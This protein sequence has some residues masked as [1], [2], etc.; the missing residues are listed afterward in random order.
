[1]SR[2][3]LV[4]SSMPIAAAQPPGTGGTPNAVSL[5]QDP[6]GLEDRKKTTAEALNAAEI[7]AWFRKI[8]DIS[9]SQRN[10]R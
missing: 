8:S 7:A 6:E 10:Q 3:L 1:M 4:R 9:G 2:L 5:S